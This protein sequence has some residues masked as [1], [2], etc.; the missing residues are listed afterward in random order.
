MGKLKEVAETI[1]IEAVEPILHDGEK[2]AAGALYEIEKLAGEA[3]VAL[4]AAKTAPTPTAPAS[5]AP[6]PTLP[7]G[8]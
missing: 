3:L 2:I 7:K 1:W 4:G 6:T 8:A 5:P